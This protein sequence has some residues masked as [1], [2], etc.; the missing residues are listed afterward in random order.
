M[1]RLPLLIC[2]LLLAPQQLNASV[3]S[4]KSSR[5]EFPQSPQLLQGGVE[6]ATCDVSTIEK[7]NAAQLSLQLHELLNAPFFRKFRVIDEKCKFWKTDEASDDSDGEDDSHE[8]CAATSA[9]AGL[10]EP[11]CSLSGT[12]GGSGSGGGGAA[13]GAA[14]NSGVS[15]SVGGRFPFGAPPPKATTSHEKSF[16]WSPATS[17]LE[18]IL[19]TTEDCTDPSKP[20]FFVDLC[21]PLVESTKHAKWVDLRDNEE[22]WTGYNG[23]HVWD[24]IYSE[25]CLLDSTQEMCYEER[26]LYKLLSGFHASVTI[27]LAESWFPPSKRLGR[28]NWTANP[29]VFKKHFEHHPE[30]LMNVHFAFV[31]MLRALAKAKPVLYDHD[32]HIDPSLLAEDNEENEE[33]NEEENVDQRDAKRTQ[34]LVR[35]LLDSNILNS[36]SDVF[37]AFDESLLFSDGESPSTALALKA[38][39]KGVFQ[40]ISSVLDCVTCQKCKLHGKVTLMGLGTALKILLTPPE[41]L[42]KQNVLEPIEV[43]ALINSI[44]KFSS[45]ITAMDVLSK[46]SW[47]DDFFAESELSKQKDKN[48]KIKMNKMKEKMTKEMDSDVNRAVR[49]LTERVEQLVTVISSSPSSEVGDKERVDRFGYV[50]IALETITLMSKKKTN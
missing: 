10:A 45:A 2:L 20:N 37:S 29:A 40:N 50:D 12:T 43:V 47:E 14:T 34:T 31:V 9:A 1:P 6:F 23:S 28:K 8:S 26:V 15:N 38:S 22:R 13:A 19:P 16:A 17:P 7:A 39:F 21:D 18:N 48:E 33:E 36:C 32:Y 49:A 24:A 35:R 46:Q 4:T 41:V 25:N 42:Q 27:H 11:A 3:H 5:G 44:G 30:R